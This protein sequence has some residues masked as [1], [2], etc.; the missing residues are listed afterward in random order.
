MD[1]GNVHLTGVTPANRCSAWESC[2]KVCPRHAADMPRNG[3]MK[4]Q[5]TRSARATKSE[6]ESS[7]MAVTDVVDVLS[8]A[9]VNAVK[10]I[11]G[12]L[13]AVTGLVSASL[14]EPGS[15]HVLETV[16]GEAGEPGPPGR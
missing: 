15:A 3:D 8:V 4:A 1:R 7:S 13:R 5:C 2:R 11:L 14:V 9:P 12:R 10:E 6:E 16:L